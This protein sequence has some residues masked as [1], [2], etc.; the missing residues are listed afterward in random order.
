MILV[1]PRIILDLMT[2]FKDFFGPFKKLGTKLILQRNFR[3]QSSYSPIN[4]RDKLVCEHGLLD[5]Y[6]D[7]SLLRCYSLHEKNLNL[8]L[9]ET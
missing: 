9:N 3:D 7:Q 5:L 1:D 4:I 8:K 6:I 2:K